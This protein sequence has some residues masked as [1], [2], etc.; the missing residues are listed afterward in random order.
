M[1]IRP[2]TNDP[3]KRD[4]LRT[5][6]FEQ[7]AG[8]CHLCEKPMT[9]ERRDRAKAPKDFATFDHLDPKSNG[10]TSYYTNLKL[11]HRRCNSERGSEPLH[12]R[13]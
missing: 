3:Q 5:R 4:E 9:L 2:F 13:R 12:Q 8:L 6:L 10:G 7:Q 1:A 11:A